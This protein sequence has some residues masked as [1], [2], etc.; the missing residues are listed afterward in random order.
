[1]N[2]RSSAWLFAVML[3]MLWL[4][5]LMLAFKKNPLD[6][7]YVV[8]SLQAARD[9]DMVSVAVQRT[10]QP[11]EKKEAQ[12]FH[13]VQE[14]EQWQLKDL[15][16][17]AAVKVESFR[18]NDI[19]NQVKNARKDEEADVTNDLARFGLDH[20]QTTVTIIGRRRPK[21][22]ETKEEGKKEDEKEKEKEKEK[23]QAN[24]K[25]KE[26]KFFLGGESA[27]K[28]YVYVNSSDEPH[29]VFAVTRSSL[30]NLFF[31]DA[32]YLRSKKLFDFTDATAKALDIKQGGAELEL[33]KGDDNL[34][35]FAK[36]ALGFADFEGP[37][38]PKGLPPG[39]KA[40]EG[41]VKGLLSTILNIRVDSDADFVPPAKDNLTKYGLV[42]GKEDLRIE[43]ATPD[44]KKGMNKETLLIGEQARGSY[45]ARLASDEGVF[46]LP[47]KLIEPVL[48]LLKDPGKLRSLDVGQFDPKTIDALT[49]RAG[50]EETKLWKPEGKTWQ[51]ETGAEKTKKGNDAA[52]QKL[53]D[54][55]QGKRQIERFHDVAGA[56]AK[57][58]D[59][60]LGLDAPTME[61]NLYSEGLQKKEEG[62]KD[63][64][65]KEKEKDK[66]K[67]EPDGG[68]VLKK[69]A[70]PALTLRFGK[71]DKET[72]TVER[73][74]ADGL[75]SRF[76]VP[77]SLLDA[78]APPEGALAFL[79]PALPPFDPGE[80]VRLELQRGP[81]K[82]EV[83]KGS[84]S[85]ADRWIVKE[86]Q[87]KADQNLADP[88]RTEQLFR[89]LGSLQAKKWVK[90]LDPKE[91]LEQYGLKAPSLTATV[92][93]KKQRIT[94]AGAAS[95][96]AMLTLPVEA[97]PLA[98]VGALVANLQADKGETVV[99]QFGKE[100]ADKDFYAKHSG[101]DLLFV[102]APEVM[103]TVRDLDLRDKTALLVAEHVIGAGAVGSIASQP[104]NGL[105]AAAPLYAGQVA[106]INAARIK[107]IRLAIRTPYELREF[108][109]QRK[110][111][112]WLDASG[113]KDFQ[114]DADKVE[115]LAKDFGQL[116]TDRWINLAGGTKT[117]Q[118]LG[119]KDFLVKMDLVTDDRTVTITVG[120]ELERAGRF[121]HATTWPGAVFLLPD[122]RIDPLFRGVGYFAKE[123]A[124]AE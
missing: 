99:L 80:V 30:D 43:V 24:V 21:A 3:S 122:A 66:E 20:P 55:L 28:K 69:D 47:A 81:K 9:Y 79:D 58:L 95:A 72:V 33:K 38:A 15:A 8:P 77:K 87:D 96:L 7:S 50:K 44:F 29:R 105:L 75:V 123:R 14:N 40:P 73:V 49:L 19:V 42:E 109:F 48:A 62:K 16:S 71:T 111:K 70:K 34:W 94:P 39:I 25:E 6:K 117:D 100:T 116:R 124:A 112:S 52:V 60:E 115:Q 113:L 17:G 11:K 5:G 107:E 32:N 110:D 89:T 59:A 10:A 46:K 67:K 97:R 83:E 36:P 23:E 13:F 90:R 54:A 106:D 64:K 92:Q 61:V 35:R 1:M 86:G 121:A 26:W 12:E 104:V 2:L 63:E 98:A 18:I 114:L 22:S 57:K 74:T 91:D 85:Q 37:P 119:P 68:F 103:K 76:V 53:L 4:F 56:D 82:I 27:D 65:E 101:S 118:K 78:A 93:I 88:K 84:G 51:I 120:A 45:F 102:V 31:A 108:A 41:G